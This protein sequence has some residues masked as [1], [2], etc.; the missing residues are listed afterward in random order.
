MA[1]IHPTAIVERGAELAEDVSIGAYAYVGGSVRAGTGCVLHHHAVVEGNTLLGKDNEIFPFALLGGKT[2]DLKWDGGH[3]PLIVGDGN[4]F[5]EYVT[6]HGPTMAGNET[7]IGNRNHFLS[8]SHVAHECKIQDDIIVSSKAVI[9][10]HVE[11]ESF[12]NVGGASA[13]HQFCRIGRHGFL[14]GLSAL[15]QDLPPVMIAEGNRAR[16]RAYNRI[17]LQRRGFSE[18]RIEG[19]RRIF[20]HLYG[21]ERDRSGALEAIGQDLTIP[22]D[23]R[24]EMLRFCGRCLRGLVGC[25]KKCSAAPEDD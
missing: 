7:R 21:N 17:G 15:V 20:R 11:V 13:V 3:G 14:G 4:V 24:E 12:A 6:V 8:Y 25:D 16:L 1:T 5:R 22:E 2:Q 9:G 10:G 23:L 18:E 19:V